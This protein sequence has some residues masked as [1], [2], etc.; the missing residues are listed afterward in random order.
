MAAA[1]TAAAAGAASRGR[2]ERFGR[3]AGDGRAKDGKLDGGFFAGTLG[4]G[5]LLLFVEDD[6]FERGF[7]I[8]ADVFVDGHLEFLLFSIIP[9]LDQ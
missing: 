1:T 7:T 6:F 8:V 5:D 2:S 3:A 4:A 9:T